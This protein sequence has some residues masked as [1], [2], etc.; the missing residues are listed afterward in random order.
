L[1]FARAQLATMASVFGHVAVVAPAPFLAA[2]Q[3][4]NYVLAASDAA[5]DADG[6]RALIRARGGEEEVLTDGAALDFAGD[7][8]VLTDDYAP[9]DQWLARTRRT[10]ARS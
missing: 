2:A 7:G 4:G 6:L 9:V 1:R 10:A 3:G 8:K 5:F